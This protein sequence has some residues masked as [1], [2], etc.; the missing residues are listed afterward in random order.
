MAA[1]DA[2]AARSGL[3]PLSEPAADGTRVEAC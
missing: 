1:N 2:T 3:P